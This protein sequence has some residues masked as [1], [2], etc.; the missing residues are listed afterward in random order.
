MPKRFNRALLLSVFQIFIK[1]YVNGRRVPLFNIFL[2]LNTILLKIIG[3]F[4]H[5]APRTG[6]FNHL[7]LIMLKFV[8]FA[9]Y[10]IKI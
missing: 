8:Y 7:A 3:I 1:Q 10:F 5:N 4:V 9:D 6:I 2:A